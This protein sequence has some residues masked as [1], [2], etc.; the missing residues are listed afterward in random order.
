M[1]IVQTIEFNS[2]NEYFTGFL[3][4]VIDRSEINGSTVFIDNKIKMVLDDS[5]E[6]K[7]KRFSELATKYL[8]HSIFLGK[9]D[10]TAE[11][12]LISGIKFKS[13]P[14]DIAP[15][16]FC[17]EELLDPASPRY[18]DDTLVCN[19]YS[20]SEPLIK[21]DATLFT[22][23]YTEGCAVLIADTT[24]I[25]E[26]FYLTNDEKKALFSIEKPTIKATIK[27]QELKDITGKNYIYVKSPYNVR[28]TL[29]AQNAKDSEIPYIFFQDMNDLKVVV[30]QENTT[31]IKASR[32]AKELSNLNENSVVNRFLNISNEAG[33]EKSAIGANISYSGNISFLAKNE[34][35]AKEVIKFNDFILADEL[36]KMQNDEIRTKL[37][38]NFGNKYPQILEILQNN[39]NYNLYEILSAILEL[40]EHSF[41]ALSDKS[42][43]FRGNGGLKIDMNFIED[44]FDYSALIG[45]VMSFKLAGVESNYLAYSIFEAFGDMTIS[46]LNQ[47]KKEFKTQ[48]IIMMGDM[49]ENSVLYSR[50]LSK[51]QLSKP[52]FSREFAISD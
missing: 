12:A 33:F 47:L 1:A 20:N 6:E 42:L 10:T 48:D 31:I 11:D 41:E 21:N 32:V 40:N 8:P 43:E 44:R 14:Y 16:A 27:S 50:I 13:K 37:L 18:L 7:L 22:P 19:H 34:Y 28:S 9:I 17:L 49:F 45:S 35:G 46:T 30:V 25:D 5:D 36:N 26:L 29:F 3:Q 51:A 38:K 23:H 15:C 4:H 2:E 52:F 24:K 39:P